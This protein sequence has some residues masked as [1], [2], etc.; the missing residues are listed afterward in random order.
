MAYMGIESKKNKNEYVTDSLC[1][2]HK[3]NT[4]RVLTPIKS[5]FFLMAWVSAL[6]SSPLM[7]PNMLGPG[8]ALGV[9]VPPG[10]PHRC[11]N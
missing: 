10:P 5:F 8:P 11:G 7:Q 4:T 3:T 6:D 1:Y 2:T 9:R